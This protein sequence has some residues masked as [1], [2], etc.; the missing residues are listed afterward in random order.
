[1]PV[2][3]IEKNAN[4]TTMSN[5]H[6][7]DKNLTLKA[8]GLL[9]LFLSLPESWNY[10]I[11]VLVAIC[12]EG[13][14]GISS[15]LKELEAGGYLVRERR[16][17]E[18]GMLRDNIYVIYELPQKEPQPEAENPAQA[19]PTLVSPALE[20]RPQISKEVIS[21]EKINTDLNK[22]KREKGTPSRQS[23]GAYRNVLLSTEELQALEAEFPQDYRQRIE[24][25]SE[26]MASTGKSYRS[27]LAT[28]R[29]WA[30]QD[31]QRSPAPQYSHDN[32]RCEEG[33]SL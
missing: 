16:R 17:D 3:R 32:Y 26:Y 33:D 12:K 8:K 1:M 7:R 25:L 27:H 9:S 22:R 23:Y 5:Y 21:T 4:Y 2:F 19:N 13:R 6:L 24:R 30:R 29:S 18:Q 14:S 31:K 15:A 28:I 20:N 11:N 10:S